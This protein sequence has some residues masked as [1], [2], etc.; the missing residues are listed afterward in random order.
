MKNEADVN[1]TKRNHIKE[2]SCAR[3]ITK[4]KKNHAQDEPH[5]SDKNENHIQRHW[6]KG[7]FVCANVFSL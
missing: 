1:L 2:E 3:R 6:L 7:Y 4:Y 5:T